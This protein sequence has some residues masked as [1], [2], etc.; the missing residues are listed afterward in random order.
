MPLA[1]GCYS[2]S[3]AVVSHRQH[4]GIRAATRRDLDLCRSRR[5]CDTVMERVL[6]ER[7]KNELR[8]KGIQRVRVDAARNRQAIAESNAHY[9]QVVIGQ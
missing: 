6:Q 8:N 4:Q 2:V 7:L 3:A 1:S 5:D 9:R